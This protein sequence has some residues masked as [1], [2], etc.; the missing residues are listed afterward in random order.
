M[1]SALPCTNAL[2]TGVSGGL[3]R[4]L[5]ISLKAVGCRV[6]ASGRNPTALARVAAEIGVEAAA[7]DLSSA[8]EVEQL[9]GV[10]RRVLGQ[11]DIL[12]NCA[13][14][15]PVEPLEQASAEVFDRCFAVNV[16]APYCLCQAFAPE[17]ADRRWG[18]IINIGSSSAYAGF[19]NTAIYCASKHALLGLTRSLHDELKHRNVR[20]FCISPG[21]I[22]TEMGR[23]VPGQDFETFLDPQEIAEFVVHIAS[24][25]GGM[26]ADEI[27]LNRMV[28]R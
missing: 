23:S 22:K 9:I 4:Q 8:D 19:K 18:R 20:C 7:A 25:D 13:G 27:R 3:G 5:A 15:F 12:V 24:Y 17:M 16:R 28:I 14:I 2:L 10:A 21:S 11:I 26:I 6:L 1:H